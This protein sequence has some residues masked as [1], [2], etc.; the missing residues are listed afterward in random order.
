M[1]QIKELMERIQIDWNSLQDEGE[2]EIIRK[3]A[4]T[5]RKYMYAFVGRISNQKIQII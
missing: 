1:N 4:K 5:A 3:Y 2:I